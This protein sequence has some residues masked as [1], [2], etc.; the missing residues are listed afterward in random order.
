MSPDK[1]TKYQTVIDLMKNSK[2]FVLIAMLFLLITGI[3][4][5]TDALSKIKNFACENIVECQEQI[6]DLD[7]EKM[8]ELETKKIHKKKIIQIVD[9]D[10]KDREHSL[11]EIKSSLEY[12]ESAD[13]E[14]RVTPV[15]FNTLDIASLF[16]DKPEVIILHW[17]MFRYDGFKNDIARDSF[18][19]FLQKLYK[20]TPNSNFIIHSRAFE[21]N[22]KGS[23]WVLN[24]KSKYSKKVYILN[25]ENIN[26]LV[27]NMHTIAAPQLNKDKEAFFIK[28]SQLTED[29][30]TKEST[31][32]R[33]NKKSMSTLRSQH[34]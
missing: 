10:S 32:Y 15:K 8:V 17:S 4:K 5:F 13:T 11:R 1:T 22:I 16:K 34:C 23:D 28:L 2:F 20:V 21:K 27:E 30:L 7:P 26:N 25:A 14:V 6:V 19:I 33:I 29:F 3:G 31:V 24:F 18:E 12:L 9:S